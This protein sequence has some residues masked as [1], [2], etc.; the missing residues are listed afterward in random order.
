MAGLNRTSGI[1]ILIPMR[2]LF[3]ISLLCALP[4]LSHA[5]AS[6][7]AKEPTRGLAFG[8]LAHTAGFGADLQYSIYRDGLDFTIGLSLSSFRHPRQLKIESAYMDQGGKDYFY[9]KKNYAYVLAP[10]FGISKTVIGNEGYS[11]ISVRTTL[12]GGPTLAILKPYYLQVAIPFNGSQ[13]YV[14]VDKYDASIYNYTNIVGEADYLLGIG[15]L[16]VNPG[17]QAKFS[18]MLDFSGKKTLIRGVEMSILANYFTSPLDLMDLTKDKQ[19]YLGASIE[20]LIGDK[21]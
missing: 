2:N 10:T 1:R 9:D 12:S 14:E 17:L 8:V 20:L 16:S 19:F 4:F 6:K 21:W 18:T 15:E 13:A 11:K 3:F 5:Q 7:A